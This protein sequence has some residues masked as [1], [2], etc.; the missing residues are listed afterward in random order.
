M[1]A[2]KKVEELQEHFRY[3]DPETKR[4]LISLEKSIKRNS[5]YLNLAEHDAVKMILNF[6][7]KSYDRFSKML[8]SQTAEDLAQLEEQIKRARWEAYREAMGW[9]E[10]IFTVSRSNVKRAEKRV[11]KIA[12]N[13]K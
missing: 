12:D 2:L 3:A 11:D 1:S 13:A 10:K 8:E 5:L 7:D 6:C 4:Q 9:F